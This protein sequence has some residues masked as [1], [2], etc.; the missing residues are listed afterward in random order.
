MELKDLPGTYGL[1]I[2]KLPETSYYIDLALKQFREVDNPMS[3]IDFDSSDGITLCKYAKIV[4]CSCSVCAIVARPL[5]AQV[6]CTKG[7]HTLE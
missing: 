6:C 3:Y 1:P 7:L 5:E 4:S 2:L